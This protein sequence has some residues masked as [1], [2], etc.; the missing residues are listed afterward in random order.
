[1]RNNKI[2]L[3]F[4]SFN[5]VHNGHLMLANYI[6]EYTDLDSVWFVVSPQNPFKDK[7]S[8][9]E[10]HHRR[11]MLEMAVKNDERFEVCDIE[12]Y[13]PKPSYT[14][15]TLV[16]LSERYPNTEF[17][18]ICG[19]D[20][21]ES[22]KKWKNYQVILDNYHILV[23]PRKNYDGGELL[24]HKSVQVIDAP[25]IEISSTFIRKAIKNKKDVRYFMPEQSYK[26]MIDMNF[27]KD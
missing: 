11:D 15:D 12:F 18:L 9:L 19:M 23:Y 1:M 16:R 20:N 17:Y 4:G 8:L 13:M 7:K 25:E 6:V 5:P 2:G 21:I 26:Y 27:Y 24:N 10:D 3:F 22:F 14:I